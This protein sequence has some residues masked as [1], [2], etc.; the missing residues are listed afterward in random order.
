MITLEIDLLVVDLCNVVTGWSGD[1]LIE[2]FI[3]LGS[4]EGRCVCVFLVDTLKFHLVIV[5]VKLY[6]KKMIKYCCFKFGNFKNFKD[7]NTYDKSY[8]IIVFHGLYQQRKG[9][10]IKITESMDMCYD[11]NEHDEKMDPLPSYD[12]VGVGRRIT[13]PF[14]NERNISFWYNVTKHFVE[15]GGKF[16]SIY[17]GCRILQFIMWE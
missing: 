12:E 13:H 16:L 1:D 11:H 10:E 8:A 3:I 14:K 9:D 4:R 5:A 2:L 15:E 7:K 17:G 6:F